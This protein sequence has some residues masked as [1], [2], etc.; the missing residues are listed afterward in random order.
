M[1]LVGTIFLPWNHLCDVIDKEGSVIVT[2]R[3]VKAMK[4]L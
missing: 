1:I 3:I 2:N 4:L